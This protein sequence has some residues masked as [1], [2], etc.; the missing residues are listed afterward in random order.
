M[1]DKKCLIHFIL[2]WY[3]ELDLSVPEFL[4]LS[5][6]FYTILKSVS[7]KKRLRHSKDKTILATTGSK[8]VLSCTHRRLINAV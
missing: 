8:N 3:K 2:R 6:K 4:L 7:F 5:T 1:K